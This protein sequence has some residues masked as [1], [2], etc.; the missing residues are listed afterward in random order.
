VSDPTPP[1]LAFIDI[2]TTG[3]APEAHDIIEGACVLVDPTTGDTVGEA[4]AD[5]FNRVIRPSH[6]DW[7]VDMIERVHEMHHASGLIDAVETL[8]IPLHTAEYDLMEW[9][10]DTLGSE[11]M[12]GRPL[13][14]A[15]A[16]VAHFESRWLPEHLPLVTSVVLN[17]SAGCRVIDTSVTRRHLELAGVTCPA[18]NER[19]PHRALPDVWL[20]VAEYRWQRDLFKVIARA[21]GMVAALP[22]WDP[23]GDDPAAR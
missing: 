7:H 22:V 8:G 2:E 16:G 19:K 13:W 5:S 21:P 20:H 4:G 10:N 12:R 17:Y 9:I 23:F 18:F 3:T 11:S 1:I 15:G 6:R 14:L